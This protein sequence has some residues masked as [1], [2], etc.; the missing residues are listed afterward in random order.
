V[1]CHAVLSDYHVGHPAIL[2]KPYFTKLTVEEGGQGAGTVLL[3]GMR[4]MGVE[5]VARGFVTEPQQG[6]RLVETY[7][8]SGIVTTFTVE[9]LG[10]GKRS[11]VTIATDAKPS[12]GLMGFIERL[13]IPSTLRRIYKAE[14]QQL[15]DYV[16]GKTTSEMVG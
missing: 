7:P 6:R 13:T 14:L 1:E 16:R 9:P 4:I 12:P 11:R 3:V 10:D 8:D 15:A 2:P 5:R